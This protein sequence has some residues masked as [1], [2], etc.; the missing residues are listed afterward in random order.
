MQEAQPQSVYFPNPDRAV[1]SDNPSL[2]GMSFSER[3]LKP[4]FVVKQL[5]D[6]TIT[7]SGWT[8]HKNQ[9]CFIEWRKVIRPKIILSLGRAFLLDVVIFLSS[10]P[11]KHFIIIIIIIA[12]Q[13]DFNYTNHDS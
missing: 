4:F 2:A 8:K 9:W 7:G 6:F 5:T 3:L 13:N 1:V 12:S 11:S 10:I